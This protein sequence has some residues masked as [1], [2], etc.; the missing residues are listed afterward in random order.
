[1]SMGRAK[2]NF[3]QMIEFII[4]VTELNDNHKINMIK[5]QLLTYT[6][7]QNIEY[8]AMLQNVKKQLLGYSSVEKGEGKC[9]QCGSKDIRSHSEGTICGDCNYVKEDI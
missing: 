4:A 6:S 7:I 8:N 9:T 3:D 5:N 1:M 2:E